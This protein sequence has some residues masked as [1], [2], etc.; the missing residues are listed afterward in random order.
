MIRRHL[1]M[2]WLLLVI[3]VAVMLAGCP[4]GAGGY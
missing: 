3:A 4:R 1:R 2:D